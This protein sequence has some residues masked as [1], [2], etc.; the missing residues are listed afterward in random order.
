MSVGK[1]QSRSRHL[2]L[3]ELKGSLTCSI[4]VEAIVASFR[5][6]VKLKVKIALQQATKAQGGS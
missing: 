4:F 2:G 3:K 6:K 1:T 5:V